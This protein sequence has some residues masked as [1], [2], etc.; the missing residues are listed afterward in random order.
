[1]K[2]QFITDE[3]GK[4]LA[5]ILPIAEYEKILEDIDELEDIRLYDKTKKE[6]KDKGKR[7]L[8]SDYLRKRKRNNA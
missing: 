6:D 8:L 7:T 2:Q 5:I 4:K 3:K 1:M